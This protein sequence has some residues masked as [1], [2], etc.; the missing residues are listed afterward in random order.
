MAFNLV[1]KVEFGDIGGLF[2]IT[3]YVFDA[4]ID[5]NANIGSAGR[6]SCQITLNNNGGQF[7]PGGTGTYGS[8][9]WFKQ[10]IIISCTGA[11]LIDGNSTN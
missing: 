2:D 6:T 4:Y 5:M 7:T 3:S 10:A 9:D 11:E 8:V 1:W